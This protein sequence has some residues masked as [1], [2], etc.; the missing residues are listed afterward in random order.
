VLS[1]KQI[2]AALVADSTFSKAHAGA[3]FPKVTLR[4]AQSDNHSDYVITVFTFG[5]LVTLSLPKGCSKRP[6]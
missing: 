5:M 2:C 6:A 4:Q 3:G 1:A